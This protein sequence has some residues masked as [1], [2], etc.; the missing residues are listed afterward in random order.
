MQWQG[1]LGEGKNEAGGK[2]GVGEGEDAG[3]GEN[4][5]GGGEPRED[6]R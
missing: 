2:N 1:T 4:G 5:E 3:G 6:D